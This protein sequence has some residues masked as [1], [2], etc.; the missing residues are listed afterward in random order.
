MSELPTFIDWRGNRIEVGDTVL[1]PPPSHAELY[2]CIVIDLYQKYRDESTNGWTRAKPTAPAPDG[3]EVEWRACLQAVRRA[4]PF[5][6]DPARFFRV[7]ETCNL[8]LTA[9]TEDR[10]TA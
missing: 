10:G 6:L 9:K 5:P 4:R 2:E 3:S 7:T 8:T 1:Y